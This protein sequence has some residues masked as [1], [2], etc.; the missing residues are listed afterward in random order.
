MAFTETMEWDRLLYILRFLHFIDNKNEHYMTDK[1][2]DRLW[3]LRTI[4][5]KLSDIIHMLNI[6]AQLNI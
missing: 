4:S 1:D 2:Y 3:K 6:T 5:D